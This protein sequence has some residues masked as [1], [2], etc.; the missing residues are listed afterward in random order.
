MLEFI[1]PAINRLTQT[2][3]QWLLDQAQLKAHIFDDSYGAGVGRLVMRRL[4]RGFGF[5]HSH[6]RSDVAKK[7]NGGGV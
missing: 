3:N 1:I 7:T 2:T 4:C 6:L 5:R